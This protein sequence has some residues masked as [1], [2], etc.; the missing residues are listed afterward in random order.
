MFYSSPAPIYEAIANASIGLVGHRFHWWAKRLEKYGRFNV[1]WV[2]FRADAT[3]L[4]A[5]RW[6]RNSC[7]DWCY[8]GVDG[9]PRIFTGQYGGRRQHPGAVGLGGQ[10]QADGQGQGGPFYEWVHGKLP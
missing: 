9:D 10:R 6:W 2:S 5:A 4:E 8:G 3:G 7:I 1:G